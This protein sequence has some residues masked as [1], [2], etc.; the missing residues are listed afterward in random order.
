MNYE[1]IVGNIGKVYEGTNAKESLEIWQEYANQSANNYGRAAG[2][3]VTLMR[4]GEPLSEYFGTI[5]NQ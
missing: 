1:V 5:N 3:D 2:E 4:D